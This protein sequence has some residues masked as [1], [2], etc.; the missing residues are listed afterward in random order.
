[1]IIV[2]L[3]TSIFNI[4]V[5]IITIDVGFYRNSGQIEDKSL[6][7][8]LIDLYDLKGSE[9]KNKGD[10][11]RVRLS[12]PLQ[13][14]YFDRFNKKIT[15]TALKNILK[16]GFAN[17]RWSIEN[18]NTTVLMIDGSQDINRTLCF[19][20][21]KDEID[22]KELIETSVDFNHRDEAY[23][24][25]MDLVKNFDRMLFTPIENP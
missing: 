16:N 9:E 3:I 21:P 25:F 13:E 19:D 17:G 22:L 5:G 15:T 6:R 23:D 14:K 8:F 1:M 4:K 10:E 2:K 12:I 24:L 11:L 18:G 7:K 20:F